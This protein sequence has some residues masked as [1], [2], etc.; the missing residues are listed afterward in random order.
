MHR[1]KHRIPDER[2]FR[3]FLVFACG[4]HT[5]YYGENEQDVQAARNQLRLSLCPSCDG[6][7]VPA[8]IAE[9]ATSN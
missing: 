1:R 8:D 5:L 2:K 3:A 6:A 4:H 7:S 9:R